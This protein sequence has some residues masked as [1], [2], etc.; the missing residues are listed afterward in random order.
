MSLVEIHPKC[1]YELVKEMK[2]LY[3]KL[4]KQKENKGGGKEDETP[5]TLQKLSQDL[6]IKFPDCLF[7]KV[8]EI[9]TY[10]SNPDDALNSC[11]PGN[12][13]TNENLKFKKDIY[14]FL[15]NSIKN[16]TDNSVIAKGIRL[17]I[18]SLEGDFTIKKY[19]N[20][21]KG[22]TNHME[23][24]NSIKCELLASTPYKYKE[25]VYTIDTNL[26]ISPLPKEAS[27]FYAM[28]NYNE[29]KIKFQNFA[30]QNDNLF[31]LKEEFFNK[32]EEQ[33]KTISELNDKVNGL[34]TKT[35]NLEKESKQTKDALFNIQI[36]DIITAVIDQFT[37]IFRV[38]KGE[39]FL[40][41]LKFELKKLVGE[42]NEASKII[43]NLLSNAIGFKDS[44]NDYGHAVKN[45]GFNSMILPEEIKNKYNKYNTGSNQYIENCDCLALIVSVEKIN[46]SSDNS[47]KKIYNL[48]KDILDVG[49]KDWNKNKEVIKSILLS[50]KK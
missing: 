43:I 1:Y 39:R 23:E 33:N 3:K 7:F 48:L 27:E 21:I 44:G 5:K 28:K 37:W 25:L 16:Y 38:K 35:K 41:D 49:A 11:F 4:L 9:K 40:N 26:G 34:E 45:I 22:L 29:N 12:T 8:L 19:I 15:L 10:Y 2:V 30:K 36:R 47:T 13:F 50:F 20:L 46:D 31:K 18:N 42:D 17:I 6:S 32:I 14:Q 24:E